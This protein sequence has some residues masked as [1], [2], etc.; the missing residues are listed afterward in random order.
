M[1]HQW[2]IYSPGQQLEKLPTLEDGKAIGLERVGTLR[3][4]GGGYGARADSLGLIHGSRTFTDVT[5]CFTN[6]DSRETEQQRDRESQRQTERQRERQP[7]RQRQRVTERD[8]ETERETDR[9]RDRES[10]DTSIL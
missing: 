8:R 2:A 10:S 1:L 3:K 4:D 7:E 5:S 9:D 6:K